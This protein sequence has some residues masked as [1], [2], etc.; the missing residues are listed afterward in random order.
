MKGAE[1]KARQS[2]LPFVDA[3]GMALQVLEPVKA[4]AWEWFKQWKKMRYWPAAPEVKV[5]QLNLWPAF[6]INQ[7]RLD[8]V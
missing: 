6:T 5:E 7:Y 3:V 8:Y 2:W 4:K 1:F